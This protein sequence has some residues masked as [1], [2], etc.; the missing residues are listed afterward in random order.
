MDSQG[1]LRSFLPGE[2]RKLSTRVCRISGMHYAGNA[3]GTFEKF[4]PFRTKYVEHSRLTRV[5][6]VDPDDEKHSIEDVLLSI[7]QLVVP[8]RR[9]EPHPA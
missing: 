3:S 2:R 9:H 6:R 7:L 1:V 8:G 4:N 5:E